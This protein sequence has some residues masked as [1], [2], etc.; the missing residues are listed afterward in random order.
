MPLLRDTVLVGMDVLDDIMAPVDR[1]GVTKDEKFRIR[2]ILSSLS[3][4]PKEGKVQLVIVLPES[5]FFD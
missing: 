1:L 2:G 3:S 4:L 5:L